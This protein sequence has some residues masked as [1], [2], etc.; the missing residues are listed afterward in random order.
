MLSHM[1]EQMID[2]W[3]SCNPGAQKNGLWATLR[4]FCQSKEIWSVESCSHCE[5]G[6]TECHGPTELGQVW[7]EYL[8]GGH[9]TKSGFE[10]IRPDAFLFKP[11]E[12]TLYLFEAIT[13]SD[14]DAI[15]WTRLIDLGHFFDADSWN[16]KLIVNRRGAFASYWVCEL[17]SKLAFRG[18]PDEIYVD[19]CT[20]D[21]MFDVFRDYDARK[22]YALAWTS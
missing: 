8:D 14:I 12:R 17:A 19:L 13:T 3:I 11:E 6:C 10:K 16:L 1:H 9:K 4:G 18:Y 21:R 22:N 2:D 15:K 7:E 20:E 5:V